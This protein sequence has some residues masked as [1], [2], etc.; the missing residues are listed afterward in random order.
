MRLV[1]AHLGAVP[2]AGKGDF[3]SDSEGGVEVGVVGVF[4]G[5]VGYIH[6]HF[7]FAR[8]EVHELNAVARN[9]GV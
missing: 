3:G 5:A 4:V 9:T 7:V 2:L 8:I 6:I 1:P